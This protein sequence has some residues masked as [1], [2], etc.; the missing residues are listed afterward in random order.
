MVTVTITP[1]NGEAFSVQGSDPELVEL[2][3]TARRNCREQAAYVSE[4]LD[5]LLVELDDDIAA[6]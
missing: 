6:G 3:Q 4:L 2:Y 1:V 5:A